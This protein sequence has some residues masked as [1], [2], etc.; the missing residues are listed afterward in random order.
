MKTLLLEREKFPREK[1]C[2][3]CLNPMA[4]SVLDALG[5]S[6]KVL[7]CTHAR[8][9]GV[10]FEGTHGCIVRVPFP[11][12][13][14]PKIGVSRSTLDD[15]LLKNAAEAGARVIEESPLTALARMPSG[16]RIQTAADGFEARHLVAADGRNSTSLRLLG[17]MPERANGERVALQARFHPKTPLENDVLLRFVTE[18][19]LGLAP[20]GGG[21]ANLCLVSRPR[22]LAEIKRR[23]I[24]EYGVP[25]TLAWRSITPLRRAPLP[26]TQERLWLAGDAARVVEPF[27]G[28]GIAYAMRTGLECARGIL[29]DSP[30]LYKKQHAD[31]YRGRLWL[32]HLA[33]QACLH[34]KLGTAILRTGA[35]LPGLM[36]FLTNKVFS[37]R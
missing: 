7:A 25:E 33:R 35:L 37:T 10:R 27:T 23:A 4:W 1:V 30:D 12:T 3:D 11:E 15:L 9:E 6:A 14:R 17:L 13:S 22:N 34:P 19:Y 18:G 24:A 20:V 21:L 8:L 36:A 26:V 2:G 31:L 5:L 29:A 16:W 28:E 32:N